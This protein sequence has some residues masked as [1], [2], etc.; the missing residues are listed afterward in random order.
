ML[1]VSDDFKTA[2]KQPVKAIQAFMDAGDITLSDEDDLISFK[3][4]CESGLCKSAMRKLEAK[5][6]GEHNLLG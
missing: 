6:L 1:V 2:M 3:V 4:S 5:Y